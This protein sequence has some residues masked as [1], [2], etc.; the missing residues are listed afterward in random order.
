M[1]WAEFESWLAASEDKMTNLDQSLVNE[2]RVN[3]T[4]QL[5]QVQVTTI[6]YSVRDGC[7]GSIVSCAS[8]CYFTVE[9]VIFINTMQVLQE[10]ITDHE[11]LVESIESLVASLASYLEH[12]HMEKLQTRF[13]NLFGRYRCLYFSSEAFPVQVWI[14]NRKLDII[15]MNS[16]AVLVRLLQFQ[17]QEMNKYKTQLESYEL[18]FTELKQLM[19]SLPEQS[20]YSIPEAKMANIEAQY[21]KL[22]KVAT[23]REKVLL[24]SLPRLKLYENSLNN[25]RNT[26]TGWEE[27]ALHLAPPTTAVLIIES[28][29]EN[30]KVRI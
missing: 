19:Q 8:C 28:T 12:H 1:N 3:L 7:M 30:I 22:G 15:Q 6:Q 2:S 4:D 5:K 10:D 9:L 21:A 14:H 26:L 11:T 16:C 24:S 18:R 25:W 23:Q 13:N 27:S 17:I 20:N 29:I